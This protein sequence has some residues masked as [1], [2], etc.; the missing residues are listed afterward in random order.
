MKKFIALVLTACILTAGFQPSI[1][2]MQYVCEGI[3]ILCW[4]WASMRV[5]GCAP[6]RYHFFPNT[7]FSDLSQNNSYDSLMLFL[8]I[9]WDGSCILPYLSNRRHD[10]MLSKLVDA[11]QTN[12]T[13]RVAHLLQYINNLNPSNNH[14]SPL[15]T[16]VENQNMGIIQML[17]KHGAHA[18]FSD[19]QKN[20][21]L[22]KAVEV[23]NKDTFSFFC[24][25][26][27]NII[28]TNKS[29]NTALHLAAPHNNQ[30]FI[31]TLLSYYSA[32]NI[33]HCLKQTNNSRKTP[34]DLAIDHKNT[35][36]LLRLLKASRPD[37]DLLDKSLLEAALMTGHTNVVFFAL[38]QPDVNIDQKTSIDSKHQCAIQWSL[39]NNRMDMFALL[40]RHGK[41]DEKMLN[42]DELQ[43]ICEANIVENVHKQ[44]QVHKEELQTTRTAAEAALPKIREG[45]CAA[46][47][48]YNSQ[49]KENA[50]YMSKGTAKLK[51]I[52]PH[53]HDLITGKT[54]V[55]TEKSIVAL[56]QCEKYAKNWIDYMQNYNS[57][58]ICFENYDGTFET[59][60]G[61][62]RNG[63]FIIC[64]THHHTCLGCLCNTI[65]T[66][67]L[68]TQLARC[69]ACRE[70]LRIKLAS[71]TCVTQAAEVNN[72]QLHPF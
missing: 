13:P 61:G 56:Q 66:A 70:D 48:A 12:N 5:L 65:N 19:E 60:E 30:A 42:D 26:G 37:L 45:Y 7:Y 1:R 72:V 34:L 49:A 21:A 43:K 38:E 10:V 8:G 55:Q 63:R 69:P 47:K 2:G 22:L 39:T 20:T 67:N 28:T 62:R 24:D 59:T 17:I 11:I 33:S 52:L 4:G 71:P 36:I 18:H 46:M 9:A 25:L 68:K 23:G 53:Y 29:G 58:Q 50:T 14:I 16:A 32:E 35:T 31:D 64:E 54:H 15:L 41:Y 57:C 51:P 44:V 27:A 3:K 40:L 6:Q